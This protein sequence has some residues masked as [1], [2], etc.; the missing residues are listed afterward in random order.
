MDNNEYAIGI[1]V[2]PSKAFDSVVRTIWVSQ[3]FKYGFQENVY[4]WPSYYVHNR[5]HYVFINGCESKRN[6]IHYG[7]PQGSILGA[8]LFLIYIND[9]ASVSNTSV[10]LLFTFSPRKYKF[11]I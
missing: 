2:D 4:K 5:A 9:I 11:K 1:F 8:L 7:V 10:P 3:L 6:V